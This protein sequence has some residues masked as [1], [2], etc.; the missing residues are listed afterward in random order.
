MHP[1]IR[2]GSRSKT[3]MPSA[4]GGRLMPVRR[5]IRQA[6]FLMEPRS[7]ARPD[8]EVCCSAVPKNLPPCLLT[9][10]LSMHCDG[11]SSTMIFQ[12]FEQLCGK[13]HDK[14]IGGR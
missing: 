14:T 3:L 12:L 13:P 11:E 1:L 4:A 9:K 7:K 8:S 6:Y 10:C 2:W 5:S